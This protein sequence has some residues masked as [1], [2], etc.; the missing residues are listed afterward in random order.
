MPTVSQLTELKAGPITRAIDAADACDMP[1]ILTY[2]LNDIPQRLALET[3]RQWAAE[4]GL[5][6]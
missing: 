4:R 2:V 1:F 5:K 6:L 3:V